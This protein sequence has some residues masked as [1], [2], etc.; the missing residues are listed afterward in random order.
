MSTQSQVLLFVIEQLERL[1][2]PYMLV[3]S[4]ASNYWGR[5]RFTHDADIIIEIPTGKAAP[6]ASALEANFYAPE[7]V[8][9]EAIA[10]RSHFNVIHLEQS[11]KLESGKFSEC[12]HL[13]VGNN[14][15]A[16]YGGS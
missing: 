13:G 2:I 12:P 9:E 3:G 15:G 1:D 16:R 8:I 11:F 14:K 5:P 6:L 10:K 4:F 7:F